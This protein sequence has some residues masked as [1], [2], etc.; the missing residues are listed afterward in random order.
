[1]SVI[2]PRSPEEVDAAFERLTAGLREI[3]G[4]LEPDGVTGATLEGALLGEVALG[5]LRLASVVDAHTA[6]AVQAWRTDGSWSRDGSRSAAAR[7]SR[8]SGRSV[9]SC[10]SLLGRAKKVTESMP[11]TAAAWAAGEVASERVDV[12]C[13]ANTD[14]RTDAF[15]RDE[16][17]LLDTTSG[18]RFREFFT[19]AQ[20]WRNQADAEANA[21]GTPPE[22]ETHLSLVPTFDGAVSVSGVLDPVGGAVV[23]ETLQLIEDQLRVLDRAEGRVRSPGAR[24]AAALVEMATRARSLPEGEGRRPVPLFTVILGRDTFT[25]TCELFTGQVIR[26]ADLLGWLD[27]ATAQFFHFDSASEASPYPSARLTD[28]SERSSHPGGSFGSPVGGQQVGDLRELPAP[29]VGA[30]WGGP[31]LARAAVPVGASKR[32]PRFFTGAL[33]TAIQ[34]RDRHCQHPS[35]CDEPIARCDADHITPYAAGGTTRYFSDG[36]LQCAAHNRIPELHDPP[37][38]GP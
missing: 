21:D 20:Y 13:R 14:Q 7:L 2:Q 37:D 29:E 11:A 24:R 5:M 32:Q 17:D 28:P 25:Q 1:M 10:R 35:G 6:V 8:E 26:P 4:W 15:V 34:L 19:V 16:V 38:P 27:H 3:C 30:L 23:A 36:R 22:P 9:S 18:L 12:L 31:S 33:R